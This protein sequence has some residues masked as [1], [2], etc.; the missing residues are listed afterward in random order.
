MH[1]IAR[2]ASLAAFLLAAVAAL[3]GVA[4]AS[5]HEEHDIEADRGAVATGH[6][7]DRTAAAELAN[8]PVSEVP[9]AEPAPPAPGTF[10]T[11]GCCLGDCGGCC[12]EA[13]S[14]LPASALPV[15]GGSLRDRD[16]H[17][18]AQSPP[19]PSAAEFRPARSGRGDLPPPAAPR[20]LLY[21]SL[22][23]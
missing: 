8:E 14:N 6:C 23:L 19:T 4:A 11:T 17:S 9:A 3:P 10:A 15:V 20:R 18:L 12:F 13:P 7:A 5:G 2:I 16:E 21:A 1:R 22:R